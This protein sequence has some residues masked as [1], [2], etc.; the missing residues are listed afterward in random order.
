MQGHDLLHFVFEGQTNND[1]VQQ[2]GQRQSNMS[3]KSRIS[4]GVYRAIRLQGVD[5]SSVDNSP[6]RLTLS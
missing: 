4:W 5:N 1:I 6:E 2:K 3:D